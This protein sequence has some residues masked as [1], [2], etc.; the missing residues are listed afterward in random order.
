MARK[1][2]SPIDK[3]IADERRDRLAS[4]LLSLPDGVKPTQAQLADMLG[5]DVDQST[6]SRDIATLRRRWQHSALAKT[7]ARIGLQDARYEAM[8][9]AHWPA[10]MQGKT[11]NAEVVMQ[12]MAQQSKLLGLD[13]PEKQDLNLNHVIREYVG[14][15]VEDV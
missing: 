2:A 11:R 8:I 4:L 9:A 5:D 15:N 1:G 6:V 13:Q 12:A 3:A 7:D 14:I 10:A